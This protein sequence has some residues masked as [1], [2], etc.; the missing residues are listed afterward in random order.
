MK[1]E[2][3]MRKREKI[4]IIGARIHRSRLTKLLSTANDTEAK[5][6]QKAYASSNTYHTAMGLAVISTGALVYQGIKPFF[7]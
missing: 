3:Q 6:I 4:P 1:D 2:Y 5:D 7:E